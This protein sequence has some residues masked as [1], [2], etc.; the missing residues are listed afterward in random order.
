MLYQ[1]HGSSA[2]TREKLLSVSSIAIC[3]IDRRARVTKEFG[4][5]LGTHGFVQL[6]FRDIE[7]TCQDPRTYSPC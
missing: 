1:A 4:L 3:L 6:P 7:R 2:R 5:R